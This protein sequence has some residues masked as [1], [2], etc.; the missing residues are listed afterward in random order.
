MLKETEIQVDYPRADRFI[1]CIGKVLHIPILDYGGRKPNTT[2]TE[3]NISQ[4]STQ[5][6]LY[7]YIPQVIVPCQSIIYL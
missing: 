4:N 5:V 1:Q 2:N 7:F 6:K 3:R